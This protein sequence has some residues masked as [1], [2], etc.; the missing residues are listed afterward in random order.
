MTSSRRAPRGVVLCLLVFPCLVALPALAW[1]PDV[2]VAICRAAM[3]ISAAA[4][5]RVPLEYRDTVMKELAAPD[6]MDK[7]CRYHC[8]DKG[9][10]E[11]ALVAEQILAQLLN[12]KGVLKPYQRAQ[13]V[14]RYLHYVMDAVAPAA[15]RAENANRLVNFFPNRD[16]VIFR[17]RHAVT[18]PLSAALRARAAD[19]VF[20]NVNLED[21]YAPGFR[22][23]VNATA[24]ALLLLPPRAGE[25]PP[26][27]GPVWFLVNRQDT[28]LAGKATAGEWTATEH[29]YDYRYYSAY[30]YTYEYSGSWTSWSWTPGSKGGGD[31][32]RKLQ[33]MERRGAQLVELLGRQETGKVLLRG[34]FFNNNDV[35]AEKVA[36]KAGAWSWTLPGVMPP[37]SLY[38][39]D[40]EAPADILSRQLTNGYRAANCNEA[41]KETFVSAAKRVVV[42]NAG[43]TPR[44]EYSGQPVDLSPSKQ[45]SSSNLTP[46]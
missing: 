37:H 7:D 6:F 45:R 38:R 2:H 35:C 27:E 33:I 1:E 43:A 4:E 46:N 13:A 25:N 14:G 22:C 44:F 21:G 41:P 9:G 36:L 24:D 40:L 32:F 15:L 10:K 17:E 42:G 26:D 34:L 29:P 5:A 31:S 3:G 20:G 12:P 11:P 28:G 16:F 18:G 23:V 19:M 39:F 8:A 30:G